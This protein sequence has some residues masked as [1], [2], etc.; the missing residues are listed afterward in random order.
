LTRSINVNLQIKRDFIS[1]NLSRD[2]S[3]LYQ[4]DRY[5]VCN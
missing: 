4:T 5:E 3:S 2:V 1:F